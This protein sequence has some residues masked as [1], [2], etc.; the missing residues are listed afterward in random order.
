MHCLTE[1]RFGG[2]AVIEVVIAENQASIRAGYVALLSSQSDIKVVGEAASGR[3]ALEVCLKL[4]PHVVLM[5][6]HMPCLRGSA[7]IDGFTATSE[8]V[9]KWPEAK[10]IILTNW[11]GDENIQRARKAGAKGYILKD[12]EFEDI[13]KAIRTVSIG[14]EY[15]WAEI[16]SQLSDSVNL[17]SLSVIETEIL[18]LMG[19][20]FSN[21]KIS[22]ELRLSIEQVKSH[23]VRMFRKLNASNR[24][25]AINI[26]RR[27]GLIPPGEY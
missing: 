19:R 21:E 20:G 17:P 9:S 5:D 25:E 3:D 26:G 7:A 12:A 13:L 18:G 11:S 15:I 10:V 27:R 23:G 8:L 6:L 16:A 14:K 2:A 4:K 24:V 1:S 22:N